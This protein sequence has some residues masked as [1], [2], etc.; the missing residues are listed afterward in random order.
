MFKLICVNDEAGDNRITSA[1]AW[2]GLSGGGLGRQLRGGAASLP[3]I[4][5][6]ATLINRLFVAVVVVALICSK[7]FRGG[8]HN[9][10][11]LV[12]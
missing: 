12:S 11:K 7:R 1:L 9:Y 2:H 3:E 4:K 6:H 10:N 5:S 8:V